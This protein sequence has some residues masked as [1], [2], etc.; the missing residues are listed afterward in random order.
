MVDR[1]KT[2]IGVVEDNKDPKKLGR[3]KIRVVNV[4]ED[5]QTEDLPWANPWKDLNGNQY[6]L[7]E[8]GKVLVVIFDQGN[9]NSPEYIYA[10]HYNVNLENKLK[11]LSDEDYKSMKAII[12]DHKTQFYINDSEGL[13]LDYKYNNL[14]ITD[15][16]INLNLKD[17][18][19]NLNLGDANADQQAILGNYFIE[20]MEK[21]LDTLQNGGL[22]N[23]GGPTMPNPALMKL[24]LEFKSLNKLKFLSHHVNIVDNNNV[25]TVPSSNRE[26]IPQYGD[27]WTSTKDDNNLTNLKDED[28]KPK[29]G[30]RDEYNGDV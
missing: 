28:N 13:K 12:F 3:L 30:P 26:D 9:E 21:F 29:K 17:N 6:N 19:G 7:P 27:S 1:N 14:N 8:I 11:S 10:D 20:W 4:F 2:Y 16:K 5:I 23:G 22:Y 24:I 18:N 25:K 15:S